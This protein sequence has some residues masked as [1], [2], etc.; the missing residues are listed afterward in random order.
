M[1]QCLYI[2][3]SLV[4]QKKPDFRPLM[5]EIEKRE[6]R[7]SNE[8]SFLFCFFVYSFVCVLLLKFASISCYFCF[9]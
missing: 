8:F 2:L 5:L 7:P 3:G 1:V 9:I 6:V 4:Q